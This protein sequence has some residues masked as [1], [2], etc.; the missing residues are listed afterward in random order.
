MAR[1]LA[2]RFERGVCVPGDTIRD[3][4]VSGR[5]DM[6]PDAGADELRHLLLRYAATLAVA[7]VFLDG[8]FDVVVEDVIIGLW[9]DTTGQTAERTVEAIL[10]NPDASRVRLP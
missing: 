4:V 1:L 9:L 6:R 5:A 10:A 3:M 8:G 2:G 7:G